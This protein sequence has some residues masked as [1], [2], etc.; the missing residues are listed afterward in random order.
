MSIPVVHDYIYLDTTYL[1]ADCRYLYLPTV[2]KPKRVYLAITIDR[3]IMSNRRLDNKI[4][5]FF[6]VLKPKEGENH[7]D[8]I[9]N[10]KN[11]F[12][13]LWKNGESN[14]QG[15]TLVHKSFSLPKSWY[16][17]MEIKFLPM[18]MG[19]GNFTIVEVSIPDIKGPPKL[20]L[21]WDTLSKSFIVLGALDSSLG[22]AYLELKSVDQLIEALGL[23]REINTQLNQKVN[24]Y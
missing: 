22:S 7:Y 12:L 4:N 16:S 19:Q 14:P 21:Q 24:K 10:T 11:V 15:K 8:L 18:D 1:V 5:F 17:K 6:P 13:R 23:I 20:L 2:S 9:V 3:L